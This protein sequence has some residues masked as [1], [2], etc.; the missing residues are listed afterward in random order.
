MNLKF[1]PLTKDDVELKVSTVGNGYVNLLIYQTARCGMKQLDKTVGSMNWQRSHQTINGNLYC[2][3]EIWDAIRGWVGKSDMGSESAFGDKKKGESSDSFKRACV[4]W[5][6][7][8]ELYT[9][10]RIKVDVPTTASQSGNKTTYKMTNAWTKFTVEAL[11]VFNG[12]I[13]YLL[14]KND[15]TNNIFQYIKKNVIE[16]FRTEKL[17]SMNKEE[18]ELFIK[19]IKDRM[20]SFGF[21]KSSDIPLYLLDR[22][23]NT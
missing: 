11:E 20:S 15:K 22:I 12:E 19:N 4:S 2:K 6:I 8:R 23:F 18:H 17:K 9:A 5:G 3:I 10:P 7:G 1:E 14:V 21:E 16:D 13:I